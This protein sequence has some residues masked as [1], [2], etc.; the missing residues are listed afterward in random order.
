MLGYIQ[1]EENYNILPSIRNPISLKKLNIPNVS[2]KIPFL[3]IRNESYK[4]SKLWHLP[5]SL[6]SIPPLSN[7]TIPDQTCTLRILA[8]RKFWKIMGWY[9]GKQYVAGERLFTANC[10]VN[11]H[12]S[13][14]MNN[15]YKIKIIRGKRQ[16]FLYKNV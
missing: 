12:V 13:P 6:H 8:A 4:L 16:K 5:N 10:H 15:P 14:Q 7:V 11:C 9:I 1:R 3:N 2:Y